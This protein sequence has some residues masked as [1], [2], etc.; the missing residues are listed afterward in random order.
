MN[1]ANAHKLQHTTGW[2]ILMATL[3]LASCQATLPYDYTSVDPALGLPGFQ[4]E[5]YTIYSQMKDES[6]YDLAWRLE[7]LHD[8]YADRF[9]DEY[10]PI[11][12][13]KLVF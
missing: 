5:H 12:F 1:M 10:D 2:L 6:T 8:Y 3:G 4:T 11:G 7:S 13:P 9:A